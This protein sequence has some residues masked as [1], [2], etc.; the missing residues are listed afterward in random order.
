MRFM[1]SRFARL[2]SRH[3]CPA[4]ARHARAGGLA[5]R[6]RR[7]AEGE[8]APLACK[9]DTIDSRVLALL[10]LRELVPA[11]WL[12]DPERQRERELARFRSTWSSTSRRSRTAS[13]R[14]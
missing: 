10:S 8:V 12:P 6:D 1:G 3:R 13:T 14:R 9:T 2:S 4:R 5:G 11:I 7:R